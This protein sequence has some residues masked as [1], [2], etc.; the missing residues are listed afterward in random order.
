MASRVC[1]DCPA[2]IPSS[3]YKGRCPDCSRR[4]DRARGTKTERGYGSTVLDTPLGTMT[5]DH[6]RAAYQS[7]MDEGLRYRCVRCGD[8]IDG[9]FHL[10]H[11]DADRSVVTGPSHPSCNLRAAGVASHN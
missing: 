11:D 3:A 1:R 4:A 8:W 5:Y 6:C 10:D 9:E 2:I 7:R